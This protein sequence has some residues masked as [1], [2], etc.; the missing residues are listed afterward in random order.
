MEDSESETQ[1]EGDVSLATKAL[2]PY[3]KREEV[4]IEGS[5]ESKGRIAIRQIDPLPLE[6]S[7]IIPD[8]DVQYKTGG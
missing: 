1:E 4:I 2:A 5:W 3:T 6:I 8:I 7:S